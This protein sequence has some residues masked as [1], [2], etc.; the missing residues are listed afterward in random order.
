M[1]FTDGP[2]AAEDWLDSW[3][4]GVNAQAA[5][6]VELSRRVAATTATAHSDD[7][8]ITVT[9]GSGGQVEDLR[10]EDRVREFSG[11]ELSTRILAVMRDA[12]RRLTR[13][14]AD[15]VRTTVGDDTE[16]GRAVI[17]SYERRYPEPRPENSHD[18]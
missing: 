10:L 8:A 4:A 3:A 12:Q 1:A 2:D 15:E 6:A 16:T 18:Q 5:A 11:P 9:V 7:D 17:D 14:V 13:Q